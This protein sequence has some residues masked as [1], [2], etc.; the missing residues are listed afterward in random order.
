MLVSEPAQVTNC[1]SMGWRHEMSKLDRL[2]CWLRAVNIEYSTLVR[3]KTEETALGR[4]A[5]LCAERRALMVLIAA[6]RQ[7]GPLRVPREMRRLP[8]LNALRSTALVA[9]LSVGPEGSSSGERLTL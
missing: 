9:P 4:M 6:E 7:A 8:D 2:R 3:R 1:G 5:E